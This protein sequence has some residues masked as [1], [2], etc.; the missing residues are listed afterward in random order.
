VDFD[1]RLGDSVCVPVSLTDNQVDCRPPTNKPNRDVSDTFCHSD[2][3]SMKA[4]A[5]AEFYLK[6]LVWTFFKC[7]VIRTYQGCNH[8][9]KINVFFLLLSLSPSLPPFCSTSLRFIYL[10]PPSFFLPPNP[11]PSFHSRPSLLFPFSELHPIELA[12]EGRARLRNGFRA[13]GGANK[14]L[15]A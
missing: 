3:L 12:G 2:T 6:K 8:I 15:V 9:S 7:C 13:F 11:P 14:P 5:N 10:P 1:I 4:S